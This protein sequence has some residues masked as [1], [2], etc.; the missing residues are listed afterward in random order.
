M[1]Q[2]TNWGKQ[3]ISLLAGLESEGDPVGRARSLLLIAAFTLALLAPPVAGHA[4][5]PAALA[6]ATVPTYDH[7][8]TIVLENENFA[9]SWSGPDSTYLQG[10]RARGAF[11]DQY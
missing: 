5:T 4:A 9:A 3:R 6:A 1:V 11:A 10:L 7:V 8:F 2:R